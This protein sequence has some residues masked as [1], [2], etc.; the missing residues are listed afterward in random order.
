MSD[1][2]ERERGENERG[3]NERE[4]MRENERGRRALTFVGL[5]ERKSAHR[6]TIA[7]YNG[8]ASRLKD[9]VRFTALFSSCARMKQFMEKLCRKHGAT[10]T[11]MFPGVTVLALRNKY[12]SPSALGHRDINLTLG[13]E[14]ASGRV[15]LCEL[16]VNLQDMMQAARMTHEM[17]EE[18]INDFLE[19]L[20]C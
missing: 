9:L 12:S 3:E 4:R 14:L 8:D 7:E 16:Q 2:N 19:C 18:V 17:Y 1:E 13:V 20:T 5:K 10:K 15:H 6:K 11:N